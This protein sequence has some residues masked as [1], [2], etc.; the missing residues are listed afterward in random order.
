MALRSQMSEAEG[1]QIL[2]KRLVYRQ[3]GIAPGFILGKIED[4]R[5]LAFAF[6]DVLLELVGGGSP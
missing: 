5:E 2:E 1:R 6:E 3:T 4:A